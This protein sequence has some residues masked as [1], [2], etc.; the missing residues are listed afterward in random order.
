MT[1]ALERTPFF[2]L[3]GF[4]GSGKTT[5]LS[6][7]LALGTGDRTA[8]LI[9]EVGEVALDHH[10]LERIDEDVTLLPSGCLC[11]TLRGELSDAIARV[12]DL[13]PARVVLETTGLADP[14]PLL[15]TLA[16]HPAIAPRVSLARVI[17]TVDVA[18]GPATLREREA[19]L[20]L[21]LADVVARTKLD[22]ATASEIAATSAHLAAAHPGG[23]VL[24]ALDVRAI[25][26]DE[27]LPARAGAARARIWLVRSVEPECETRVI[28]LPSPVDLPVLELWL[29]AV[30]RLDGHALLR[31]KGIVEHAGALHV[32]QS[33]QHAV[34]P[35]RALVVR[36]RD[37]RGSRLV[38]ISRG[39]D[40]RT[41]DALARSAVDAARGSRV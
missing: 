9:N 35:T 28:E 21:D 25:F 24:D 20:Q 38:V 26:V 23:A 2:V 7:L 18:R 13:R 4:L 32:L 29:R 37:W 3:T 15:H 17:A 40:S 8:V 36:P 19:A 33:A 34:S 31:I 11:C 30:A 27:A 10:L 39:L 16:T 6:R 5:L 1:D 41:L 22:V 12:L 14:A